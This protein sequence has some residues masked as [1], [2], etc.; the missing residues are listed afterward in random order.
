MPATMTVNDAIHALQ[1]LAN[2]GHGNTPLFFYNPNSPILTT[3][4][5][6]NLTTA[7]ALPDDLPDP[8]LEQTYTYLI[9]DPTEPNTFTAATIG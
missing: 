1:N 7:A 5:D 4:G 8:Q 9:A 3:T 2:N 6:I